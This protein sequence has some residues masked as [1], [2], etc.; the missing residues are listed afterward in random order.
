M[1][2]ASGG[3][4]VVEIIVTT[5][6]AGLFVTFFVQMFRTSSNQQQVV[7]NRSAASDI[8]RSNLNKFPTSS[9]ISPAYVC[10]AVGTAT[11]NTNNLTIRTD[12]PGTELL[13]ASNKEADPKNLGTLTQS[14]RAF[15]PYGCG[16]NSPIKIISS[17]DYGPDDA[18]NKVTYATFIQ[19]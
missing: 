14:V 2:R 7:I 5:V 18:R 10:D 3:F 6:I 4:T 16:G 1:K 15:S 11:T 19:P 13:T 8:A 12:A 17:V 9:S